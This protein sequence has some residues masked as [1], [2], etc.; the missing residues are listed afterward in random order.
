KVYPKR[1][2]KAYSIILI[3]TGSIGLFIIIRGELRAIEAS[4]WA[5]IFSFEGLGGHLSLLRKRSDDEALTVDCLQTRYFSPNDEYMQ[6]SLALP[7]VSQFVTVAKTKK[8]LVYMVT[9]LKVA[10]GAKLAKA[11]AKTTKVNG[12]LGMTDP[13][14]G[15]SGGASAGYTSEDAAAVG[16]DASTPFILGI[17]VRKIWWD[18]GIRNTADKLA[19]AALEDGKDQDQDFPSTNFQFVDDFS[20]D[21][22][23]TSSREKLFT[24]ENNELGIEPSDWVLC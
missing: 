5:K 22:A 9:G 23:D 21:E 6:K 14:G 17:R 10:F 3:Y 4:I 20:V 16:F 7:T 18:N 12:K 8:L 1:S 15:A 11:N 19:G 13:Q 24:N 2:L